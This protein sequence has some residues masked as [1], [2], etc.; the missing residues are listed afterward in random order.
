MKR[1]VYLGVLVL[2]LAMVVPAT[3]STFVALSHHELVAQSDAVVQGRVLKVSSFW[4]QEGRV[5]MTEAVVQ[6]EEKIRGNAPSVVVVR[7]F[8]GT[9]GGYTVEAHGFPKFAVNDHLVL[10][11]QNANDTAEVTGYQQ[12]QYRIVRDK[13]GVEIAVSAV[14]GGA[15][16]LSRDGR[17]VASPKAM[18]LDVLKTMIRADVERPS[19]GRN[20]N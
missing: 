9:V 18:R 16:L 10:Y 13:S 19:S 2:A 20:A 1:L 15:T 17:P 4:D 8:G 5:I 11:L 6:I 12:G 7:T 14:D 3:A